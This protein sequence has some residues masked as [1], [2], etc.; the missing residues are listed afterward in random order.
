MNDSNGIA[1]GFLNQE[2]A[3]SVEAKEALTNDTDCPSFDVFNKTI[4]FLHDE[5]IFSA[6][7]I[8]QF[9]GVL[10]KHI[11][12]LK[13]EGGGIMVSDLIDDKNGYLALTEEEYER[14]RI[15]DPTIRIQ[16]REFLEYGESKEGYWTSDKFM[17]QVKVA[18]KIAEVKYPQREEYKHVWIFDHSSCHSTKAD[19]SLDVSK[20]NVNC[21]RKQRVMR[22][23]FYDGKLQRMNYALGIPKGLRVVLDDM[24]KT[25][26]IIQTLNLKRQEWSALLLRRK[27]TL[28]TYFQSTTV[29]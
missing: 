11:I 3:P 18:V 14:A 1:L 23:G 6:M 15:T 8:S 22:D 20:M 13:S 4:I 10:K 9:S 29:N 12:K 21:G 25:L 5:S 26:G 27:S 17:E 28:L 2:N 7:K 24:R 19:D 16:A